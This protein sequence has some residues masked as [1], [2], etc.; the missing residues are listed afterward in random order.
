MQIFLHMNHP[1]RAC[2]IP[3]DYVSDVRRMTCFEMKRRE[4][5]FRLLRRLRFAGHAYFGQW[6]EPLLD[7]CHSVQLQFAIAEQL[8]HEPVGVVEDLNFVSA[9][10]HDFLSCPPDLIVS[11]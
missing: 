6:Q 2:W 4:L 1:A 9:D 5:G 11:P 10:S 3:S 8:D 7:E